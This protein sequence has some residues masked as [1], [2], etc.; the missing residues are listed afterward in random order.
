MDNLTAVATLL[1]KAATATNATDAM[2]FA[3]AA[4]NAANA[5][6]ALAN[7]AAT[8]KVTAERWRERE[9]DKP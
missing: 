6:S 7:A 4:C 9:R 1:D 8:T 3:Q 5:I 2:N